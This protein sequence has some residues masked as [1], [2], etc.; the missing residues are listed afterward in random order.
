M[1]R[2]KATQEADLPHAYADREGAC[3]VCGGQE[4]DARHLAW[5]QAAQAAQD[6]DEGAG[7]PRELGS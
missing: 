4:L 3:T 6:R 2:E 7:M 1:R 5:E